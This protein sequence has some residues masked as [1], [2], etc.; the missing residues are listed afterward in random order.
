MKWR[1]APP[2]RIHMRRRLWRSLWGELRRR[3]DGRR[4]S[5]AFLLGLPGSREVLD[6]VYF[7]DL[8]PGCLVGSIA[9]DGE[10]FTRLWEYCDDVGMRVLAD[11]HTH[12]TAAVRLSSI[13]R[14][15]PMIA[16]AGH[17]GIIVPHYAA[18]RRRRRKIG[19]HRYDGAAG[20]TSFFGWS[21]LR[22]IGIRL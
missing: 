22:R 15:N 12:P 19:V 6:V 5:G 10:G 13:D 4:E 20:W 21:A 11:V 18:G 8:D 16:M 2:D 14:A 17:I 7:D 1:W 9:L 3:G